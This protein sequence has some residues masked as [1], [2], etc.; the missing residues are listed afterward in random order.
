MSISAVSIPHIAMALGSST[1]NLSL[2][3]KPRIRH[4]TG[5]RIHQ[6]TLPE[7]LSYAS[8]LVPEQVP[9]GFTLGESSRTVASPE[10]ATTKPEPQRSRQSS[11]GP[12]AISRDRRLSGSSSF[13]GR[14]DSLA[15][16]KTI[17]PPSPRVGSVPRARG[18]RHRAPTLAGEALGLGKDLEGDHDLSPHLHGS[19]SEQM[20]LTRKEKRRLA[21]CFVVFRLPPTA[22][23]TKSSERCPT[24]KSAP[25]GPKK[26]NSDEV[27][28]QSKQRESGTRPITISASALSKSSPSSPTIVTRTTSLPGSN[29]NSRIRTPSL[30]SHIPSKMPSPPLAS[31]RSSELAS[32]SPRNSSLRGQSTP[33]ASR[34]STSIYRSTKKGIIGSDVAPLPP[35]RPAVTPMI[36][37]FFISPIHSPS[38]FPRFSD[39]DPQSDFAPWLTYT[40]LASTLVEIQIWVE[41]PDIGGDKDVGTRKWK[42][43]E[44][45]GGIVQLDRLTRKTGQGSPNSLELTFS[46]DPKGVYCIAPSESSQ[47]TTSALVEDQRWK[48]S[49]LKKGVG[50]GSLHQLVNMHAVIT[51]TQRDIAQVQ[52]KVNKLLD[53]DVDNRALK[54]ELSERENRIAW[55]RNKVEE[56]QKRIKD[57]RARI[58]IKSEELQTRRDGLADADEVDNALRIQAR[59]FG[60]K[61]DSLRS[62]RDSL[63][64]KIHR[65]RAS[66]IQ[67]LD[68]LFPIQPSDPSILLY[69]ILGVP[70]PIPSSA[71]DPAPP[72]SLPA[73][74]VDERTTA[75]ALGYAAM[76]VQILGNLRGQAGALPYPITCA[77]SKSA[78]KDV[79]SVMQGP[80]SFPLYA[81]GVERYRYEYGVFLLNKN[82]EV[83][84]QD[85]NIRLLDLRQTLPNLKNL[86]LM[87][88]S[89]AY[90]PMP[91]HQTSFTGSG[92]STYSSSRK[93]SG[94]W[95]HQRNDSVRLSSPSSSVGKGSSL[96][97]STRGITGALAAPSP[98]NKRGRGARRSLLSQ[99]RMERE[100]DLGSTDSDESELFEKEGDGDA[101]A[102]RKIIA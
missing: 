40:D 82:I 69:T 77:G 12:K 90:T 9:E 58:T 22:P 13:R 70:L 36:V 24:L 5:I 91:K 32:L 78:V 35:P 30:T 97:I 46:F 65:I 98:L 33:I 74:K 54:R 50:V 79:V 92:V 11:V 29:S 31:P 49:K 28:L 60:D 96:S 45:V 64:P 80:R 68:N 17:Q 95:L 26:A 20:E 16:A 87:L 89:S 25:P 14:S 41:T 55:I 66:H 1:H 93:F 6:L 94:A 23:E 51:D 83:L 63:L 56:V 48:D 2:N 39:L 85:A 44:G 99:N 101:P 4:I 3:D 7:S 15:S 43:L 88:S 57:T 75:V 59:E 100:V 61:I 34:S 73:H 72:I 67:V 71:K 21:R 8:R 62:E 86:L 76:V 10:P 52:S 53:E 102:G 18:T 47:E 84:M 42:L 38:I 81:K 37:P 19:L 27:I